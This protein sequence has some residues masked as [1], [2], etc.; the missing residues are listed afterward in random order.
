MHNN[1]KLKGKYIEIRKMANGWIAHPQ[2]GGDFIDDEDVLVYESWENLLAA[3]NE[4]R[5]ELSPRAEAIAKDIK[6]M[7]ADMR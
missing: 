2:R 3:L 7:L 1:W 4:W 5:D 6:P